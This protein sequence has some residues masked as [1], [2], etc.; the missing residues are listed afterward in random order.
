MLMSE[1]LLLAGIGIVVGVALA[2]LLAK[3]VESQL[4][5]VAGRDPYTIAG[6]VLMIAAIAALAGYGPG[7]RAVGIHPMEA[8]R[9]E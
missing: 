1:V 9:W 3:M 8:L 2:W 6:A 5:G 4:Y 7:R